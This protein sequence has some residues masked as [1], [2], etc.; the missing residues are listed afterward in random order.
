MEAIIVA[1]GLGSR[2]LP[3]TTHTP[4]HLLPVAGVPLVVHQIAKLA[5]AGTDHV[6]LATSYRAEMF[7]PALGDGSA[8]NLRLT[9]VTEAEPRGTGGAIRNVAAHLTSAPDDPVV[10]LNGDI[11]S[12]HDLPAQCARHR[13]VGADVTLHLVE[14][15]DAR[16]YGCVPTDAAGR[17][18]GFVEKSPDPVSHQVNAGCYVFARRIIDLIP[19]ERVVSVEREVF[20]RLLSDGHP[21]HGY[22]D[23][24]YWLD[25][26][27]PASLCRASVDLV[28]GLASSP[29]YDG[30]PGQ[31]WVDPSAEVHGEAVVTGGSAVGP[32]ALVGARSIVDGSVI[33]AGAVIEPGGRVLESVVGPAARIGVDSTLHHAVV[34]DRAVVGAGCELRHGLRLGCETTL[35]PGGVR[36]SS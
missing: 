4:K 10:I 26:G 3:L 33:C 23:R 17:V 1:G 34:G 32:G 19:D 21:V 7:E 35:A 2:L 27:T 28:R 14:V 20:P 36:F 12:G 18:Q 5:Q 16:D 8:W 24:S 30:L 22:V 25:V 13:E 29:A 9:Y 6:V 31:A 11:L 15:A